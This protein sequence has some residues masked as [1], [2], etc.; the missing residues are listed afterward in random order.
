MLP[1]SVLPARFQSCLPS[2]SPRAPFDEFL[3]VL[4]ANADN[5]LI[6]PHSL[7]RS[8]LEQGQHPLP[9]DSQPVCHLLRGM[10]SVLF[11]CLCFHCFFCGWMS[12]QGKKKGAT[13]CAQ[14]VP[15]LQP[16]FRLV[17]AL[18]LP[19]MLPPPPLAVQCPP[20]PCFQPSTSFL[21]FFHFLL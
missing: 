19:P 18:K 4:R 14:F 1:P 13:N 17:H 8:A 2:V 9:G 10:H 21:Q 15:T 7:K 3:Q 16:A 20:A 5:P 6:D 12:T 11:L